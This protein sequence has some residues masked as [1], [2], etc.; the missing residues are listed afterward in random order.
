MA[1]KVTFLIMNLNQ[2]G[3]ETLHATRY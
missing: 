2:Q 3:A 1:A